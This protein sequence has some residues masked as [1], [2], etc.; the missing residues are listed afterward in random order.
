MLSL[1]KAQEAT[2]TSILSLKSGSTL[3]VRSDDTFGQ[4][5]L[6]LINP[7]NDQEELFIN[8]RQ[9][10]Y[11]IY[12]IQLTGNQSLFT[13]EVEGTWDT[14]FFHLGPSRIV[15]IDIRTHERTQGYGTGI[16][17]CLQGFQHAG[18]VLDH[19]VGTFAVEQQK[20]G[21]ARLGARRSFG[22]DFEG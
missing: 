1:A 22:G 11:R 2:P 4:A 13:L 14:G 6:W 9:P 17:A 19:G 20:K 3:L 16:G 8:L 21:L 10:S 12:A 5:E 7:F 15:K 18:A